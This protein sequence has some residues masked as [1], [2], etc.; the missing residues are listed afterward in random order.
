MTIEEKKTAGPILVAIDFSV[1][2]A[3][4]L[5]WAVRYAE[6]S[7][8]RLVLLHVVHEPASRPGFYR[9]SKQDL[10]QPMETVARE[11]MNQFLQPLLQEEFSQTLGHADRLFVPGLP[12]TRI[13]EVAELLDADSIVVGSRGRTGLPPVLLGSVAERVVELAQCPVVVVT[14]RR[15]DKDT[16]K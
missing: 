5:A 7:G 9:N 12:P 3:A 10:L 11:M 6:R 2:S 4:A 14:S 8:Q 13:V 16:E 1:D 15:K